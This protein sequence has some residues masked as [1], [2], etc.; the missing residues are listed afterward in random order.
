MNNISFQGRT[1]LCLSPT[2]YKKVER[3]V[4]STSRF[5]DQNSD[6]KISNSKVCAL[7]TIPDYLTVIMKNENDGFLRFV[8]LLENPE[9]VLLDISKRINKLKKTAKRDNLT[10]W[11]LGGT[12]IEGK[13]GNKIV[14][15]LNQVA[16]LICDRPDIETSILIG[17]NTG[18]E[19]Y[20]IRSGVN[21]LKLALERK[22]NPHNKVLQELENNFDIVELNNTELSYMA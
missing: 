15:T 1:E 14:H 11:I 16:D 8:P 18:E 21:Q 3:T 19:T 9:E 5:L 12:R 22:M 17:S 13:Q 20:I 7:T 10:A 6:C 4:R 2:A